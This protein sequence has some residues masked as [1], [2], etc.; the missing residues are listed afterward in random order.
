MRAKPRRLPRRCVCFRRVRD[1]S[2][3]L[4][5]RRGKTSREIKEIKCLASWIG[6]QDLQGAS[7]TPPGGPVADLL[8][9]HPS[10]EAFLLSDWP[11][12]DERRY[13]S[14][15]AKA[16]ARFE[17]R[18]IRLSDPTDYVAVYRA[19]DALL[20]ELSTRFHLDEIGVHTSPGTSTMAA[21]WVLLSKTKYDGVRLFKSWLDKRTGASRIAAVQLPF[22]V[23]FELLPELIA[24]QAELLTTDD[25]SS[26]P[27]TNA[28]DAIIYRSEMMD[29]LVRD[30]RR[31]ALF[32]KPVLILG[33]S[34]TGKELLARAI[35][36]ASPRSDRT[37]SA[38]NC[39]AIPRELLD[40]ELFGHVKGAFTGALK[41][42][43]GKFEECQGGTL[44]L[45]EVGEMP[46]DTQIR[47]L[48]V[49][50][51]G[52]IQ[53]V[54]DSKTTTVDV[55]V[56]AATNRDLVSD[57]NSGRFRDDLFYR[58]AV[59]VLRVPPLRERREDIVPLADY[60]LSGLN[61]RA[62]DIPG[63]E[64]KYISLSAKKFAESYPWPG[65]VRELENTLARTFVMVRGDAIHGGDLETNVIS[66][67]HPALNSIG[68]GRGENFK[69]DNE[70][71]SHE[72]SF[73]EQA[74]QQAAG[75][76][77]QAA[78]LLGLPSRQTLSNRMRRLG[79]K[80]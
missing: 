10:I 75:V 20:S 53:R 24:R 25:K 5:S 74:L 7:K 47:L 23:S 16:G 68:P 45:D 71:D 77:E 17:I 19:A 49:L 14:L 18:P 34:G 31:A 42:R 40:S 63:I 35:H 78:K 13:A 57:V 79:I 11:D 9:V 58:L 39:G 8:R 38:I 41:D 59:L 4:R 48:R 29:R 56:V 30:T 3:E 6:V 32:P 73:I 64:R 67:G 2:L 51:E 26:F 50:Q 28:F 36:A 55:R 69:L 52:E 33:E 12:S 62:R 54:G 22:S 72:R 65:N 70:L 46:T 21:V 80:G 1:H 37:W 66:T 43:K 61:E 60:F 27:A 76:K 15:L 44:F